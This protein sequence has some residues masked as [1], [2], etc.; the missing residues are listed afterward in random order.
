MIQVFPALVWKDDLMECE[1]V[2]LISY[3]R[4]ADL[5]GP[6]YLRFWFDREDGDDV[7]LYFQTSIPDLVA[8]K[9]QRLTSL[10]VWQNAPQIIRELT[11]K[12]GVHLSYEWITLDDIPVNVRPST[13]SFLYP[14]L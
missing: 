2:P 12:N 10:Q 14:D 3:F 6:D 1:A 9:S 8:F 11:D 4:S 13:D 7:W 5:A